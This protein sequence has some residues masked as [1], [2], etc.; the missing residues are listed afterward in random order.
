MENGLK[1]GDVVC[2]KS[3][4]PKMTIECRVEYND[5]IKVIC[6]W[7]SNGEKKSAEF[8]LEALVLA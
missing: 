6:S 4:S 1:A 3:G 8:S 5:G 2:L 7:F